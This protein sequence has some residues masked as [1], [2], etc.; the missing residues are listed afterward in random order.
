MRH[1]H[2]KYF[3]K[4]KENVNLVVSTQLQKSNIFASLIIIQVMCDF[5]HNVSCNFIYNS[6]SIR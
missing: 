3:S 5:Y 4:K 6:L 2:V 1:T